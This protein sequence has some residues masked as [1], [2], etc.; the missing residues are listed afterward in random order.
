M[1]FEGRGVNLDKELAL[2]PFS[3][4]CRPRIWSGLTRVA[5]FYAYGVVGDRKEDMAMEYV[6]KAV[7]F[8][9]VV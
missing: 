8:I 4:S 2:G 5:D 3:G 9:T 1:L 6:Q 7:V